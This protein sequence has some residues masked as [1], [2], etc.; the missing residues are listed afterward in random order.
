MKISELLENMDHGRD[1]D[2]VEE[3]KNSLLARQSE[4]RALKDDDDEL[5]DR[6]DHM[7]TRVARSHGI[8]G[9][10][11]HD[12]W[13]KRYR[14]IPDNW[15]MEDAS[16]GGMSAGAVASLPM[17]LGAVVR[18]PNLF[19]YVPEPKRRKKSRQHK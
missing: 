19:G 14:E 17:A 16:A 10:K 11:L 13:V 4:L 8:S 15:I 5:Y 6:I 7:M 12:M 18:R 1:G 9:Q 3:L 2:A